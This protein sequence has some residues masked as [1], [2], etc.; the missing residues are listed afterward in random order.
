MS[1]QNL[2]PFCNVGSVLY[3]I[4]EI[5]LNQRSKA[6]PNRIAFKAKAHDKGQQEQD[7]G[8]IIFFLKTFQF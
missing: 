8:N 1:A 7:K 5:M 2:H 3:L 4:R 6:I